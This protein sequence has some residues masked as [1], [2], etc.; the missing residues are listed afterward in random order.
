M[1]NWKVANLGLSIS[2]TTKS[3]FIHNKSIGVSNDNF[4]LFIWKLQARGYFV[5][6]RN[7][8]IGCNYIIVCLQPIWLRRRLHPET[9]SEREKM[10][11]R[12]KMKIHCS[13]G[14]L[15]IRNSKIEIHFIVGHQFIH[16]QK[17]LSK[18]HF[19]R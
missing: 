14:Q 13:L 2:T 9:K 7:H 1:S 16:A 11:E 17:T 5:L 15:E 18:N 12:K 19:P 10:K 3:T 8:K 6:D 4:N